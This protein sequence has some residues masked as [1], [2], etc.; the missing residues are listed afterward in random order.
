MS[1]KQNP[2]F[3]G[4]QN[5]PPKGCFH[6]LFDADVVDNDD[7]DDDDVEEQEEEHEDE[8]EEA[9]NQGEG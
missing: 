9:N 2:L 5:H 3:C 8:E 1:G 6:L 4:I 7:D